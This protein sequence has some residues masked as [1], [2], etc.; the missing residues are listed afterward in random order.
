M[1]T[2]TAGP[3]ACEPRAAFVLARLLRRRGW[4][5]IARLA[6]IAAIEEFRANGG[7]VG[8][9]WAGTIRES[10]GGHRPRRHPRGLTLAGSTRT[11]PAAVIS[12]LS[13]IGRF[14]CTG[15]TGN[16]GEIAASIGC[17]L[18]FPPA[19]GR[20]LLTVSR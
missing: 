17:S 14:P 11:G 1:S 19:G 10:Y 13:R 4:R 5:R 20:R 3:V 6:A 8:G 12:G 16:P 7:R 18:V 2:S 15:T 9:P